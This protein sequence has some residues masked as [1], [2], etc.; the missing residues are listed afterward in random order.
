MEG[1]VPMMRVGKGRMVVLGPG[2]GGR[3]VLDV[4]VEGEALMVMVLVVVVGMR[5]ERGRDELG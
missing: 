1:P 5:G 2:T 3:P 4:V